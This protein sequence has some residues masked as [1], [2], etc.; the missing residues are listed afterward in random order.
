M[1]TNCCIA[2]H[3]R[4]SISQSI[5]EIDDCIVKILGNGEWGFGWQ[6]L[7]LAGGF[8]FIGRLRVDR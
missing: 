2:P 1:R 7:S 8:L 3:V 6:M 4:S 5:A